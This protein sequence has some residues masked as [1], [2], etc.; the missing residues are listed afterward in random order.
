GEDKE[1][2]IGTYFT[3]ADLWRGPGSKPEAAGSALEKILELDPANRGAYEQA[4]DLFS[5]VNDW[6]SYAQVMDRYQPNLVTE[7]EKL[8]AWRE[9]AKVQEV[10]LGQ[11]D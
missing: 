10:K 4:I 7:D 5:K 2:A 1:A 9:L 8:A 3:L 6:R 11:K